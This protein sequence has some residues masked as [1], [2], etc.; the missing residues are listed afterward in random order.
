MRT[1]IFLNT[2][3]LFIRLTHLLKINSGLISFQISSLSSLT[4]LPSLQNCNTR[5]RGMVE[6]EL[7]MVYHVVLVLLSE[8]CHCHWLGL[9]M[10]MDLDVGRGD[11]GGVEF[12][13]P[14]LDPW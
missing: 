13:R 7:W 5:E 14:R 1:F 6:I 4:L 8:Q 11:Y 2:Q 12:R 9:R 3:H 10:A